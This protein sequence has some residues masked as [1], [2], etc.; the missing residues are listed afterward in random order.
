MEP[1]A[2]CIYYL[3][4]S[5][6][7][8]PRYVGQAIRPKHRLQTHIATSL[9]KNP[10]ECTYKENWIRSVIQAGDEVELVII[11]ECERSELNQREIFWYEQYLPLGKLTNTCP[12]GGVEIPGIDRPKS[13]RKPHSEETKE[14][15]RQSKLGSR[16]PNYGKHPV[17]SK[18]Y[19]ENMSR[20]LK[21]SERFQESRKS[22]EFRRKISEA[23]SSRAV[24]VLDSEQKE[25]LFRFRNCKE[26]ADYFGMTRSNI[27]AACKH[28]RAIGRA[29]KKLYYVVYEDEL[30]EQ[31]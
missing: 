20:I 31:I 30:N 1:I 12:P 19:R 24:C 9:A 2:P 7:K 22:I 17:P 13:R 10:S 21:A 5:L 25:V 4:S 27:A 26:V 15:I 3:Q 23:Q 29:L 6:Q 16:N 11:E 18:E 28:R 14:K 8:E